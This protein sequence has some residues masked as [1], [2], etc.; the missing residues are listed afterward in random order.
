V[1]TEAASLLQHQVEQQLRAEGDPSYVQ[2]QLLARLADA[3]GPR[4]DAR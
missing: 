4:P 3:R 2:F 1:L